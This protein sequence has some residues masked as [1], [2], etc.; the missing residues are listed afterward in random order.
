VFDPAAGLYVDPRTGAFFDA[1]AQRYLTAT[2]S[3]QVLARMHPQKSA[4]GGS[5]A[6]WAV[7]IV[8]AVAA[9]VG[10][11]LWISERNSTK[12][13]QDDVTQYQEESQERLK[14]LNSRLDD[15]SS[16]VGS[17][18]VDPAPAPAP[19]PSPAPAPVPDP[20]PTPEVDSGSGAASA[21]GSG[22]SADS[23]GN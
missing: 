3:Q 1:G 10:F 16:N 4:S 20:A 2:E 19:S 11:G 9:F 15:I 7:A 22:S 18:P 5:G 8:L 14:D 6:A 12:A 21:P 17:A 13:L 23:L